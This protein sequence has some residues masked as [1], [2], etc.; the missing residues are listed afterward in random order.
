MKLVDGATLTS[1]PGVRVGHWTDGDAQT[2]CTVID[3]PEPNVIAGETRGAAPGTREMALL[4]PGMSVEQAQAIVLCGGSAYGLAA[5]DGVMTALEA[6]GRGFPTPGGLVPIV[7][8]AVLYDL[9]VGDGSVRPGPA[10]GAAAYAARSAEP[11]SLGRVGAGTGATVAKWRGTL[12]PGGL[13]SAVVDIGGALVGALVVVNAL[14][15]V[16]DL[17]G[18]ALTGGPHAPGP[19]QMP[20]PDAQN[21]SLAV[22]ATDA[23]L[24]RVQLGRVCVRA[25]DAFGACLRP[26]HTAFDGDTCFATS[27]GQ[28]E[29]AP[30]DVAEAAFQAVG[31]AIESAITAS[32]S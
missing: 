11:V 21:T 31:R 25:H 18:R 6:D 1:I 30:H 3:L 10:E 12:V 7:P 2:G 27:V 9:M 26:A 16:F 17:E 28:V 13:G 24:S 19:L 20:S 29:V 14:G 5:A 8:S 4:Q 22:V 15:D 23:A 32:S